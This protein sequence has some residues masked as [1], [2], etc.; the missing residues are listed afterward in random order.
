MSGYLDTQTR[1]LRSTD[2]RTA[3][4]DATESE[5]RTRFTVATTPYPVG[6][7]GECGECPSDGPINQAVGEV[8]YRSSIFRSRIHEAVC[9]PCLPGLLSILSSLH[10]SPLT[11]ALYS[12]SSGTR[13]EREIE[14]NEDRE[15]VVTWLVWAH[16][17]P[18]LT[19]M[20]QQLFTAATA[21]LHRVAGGGAS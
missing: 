5:Q 11:V 19:T 8:R 20:L 17:R 3:R 12:P 21:E 7:A 1:V 18:A 15:E 9:L 16:G 10:E 2:P 4:P 14:L 13:T 6:G